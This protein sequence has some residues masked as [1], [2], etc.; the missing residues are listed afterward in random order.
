MMKLPVKV[1]CAALIFITVVSRIDGQTKDNPLGVG[2]TTGRPILPPRR[3][4]TVVPAYPHDADS[5]LIG[6]D[7]TIDPNGHVDSAKVLYEVRGATERRSRGSLAMGVRTDSTERRANLASHD[8]SR[9]ESL[10]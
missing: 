1:F 4:R 6:L 2:P 5:G 7:V 9:A 8:D 3:T 10:E